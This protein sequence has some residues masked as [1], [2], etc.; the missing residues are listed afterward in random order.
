MALGVSNL[1]FS[2]PSFMHKFDRGGQFTSGGFDITL[3]TLG[4]HIDIGVIK[5]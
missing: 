4:V 2:V 1:G 3:I 5:S